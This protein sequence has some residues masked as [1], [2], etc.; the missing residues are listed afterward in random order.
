M[1]K[2]KYLYV[3]IT[4]LL[5]GLISLCVVRW[6]AW[7]SMPE[8]PVWTGET[9]DYSF[10]LPS[11]LNHQPAAILVLGDV[12]NGLKAS[13]YDSLASRVPNA[14]LVLQTGDWMERGQNYYYQSLLHEWTRSGLYGLPVL[15]TPG[16]HEYDKAFPSKSLSAV[17]DHAFSHPHNGPRDVP[18]ATYY[19]D[20]PQIRLI[21]IDTNPLIRLVHL[22]RTLTWLRQTMYGAGKRYVVVMMH[23]PVISI[24]EWR[25]NPLIFCTFRKALGEADLVLAGH[26]HRYMRKAPFVILNTAGDVK[27]Q[28]S[29]TRPQ[30]ASETPVYGVLA[31]DSAQLAFRVYRLDNGQ[32]IDSMYVK[33]H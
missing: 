23:H 26:D 27:P 13:D 9:I 2:R 6:Q 14:E 20:L 15:A 22:T 7:F 4:I 29:I 30:V 3:S 5:A 12:H 32:V 21:C 1:R 28:N 17:W 16:N 33:H 10:P 8:E 24:A 11:N 18:G 19:V 31:A 25:F